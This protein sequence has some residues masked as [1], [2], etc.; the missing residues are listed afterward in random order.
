MKSFPKLV[1]AVASLLVFSAVASTMVV[2]VSAPASDFN[3][4]VPSWTGTISVEANGSISYSGSGNHVLSESSTNVYALNGNVYGSI[5]FMRNNSEFNGN[6]YS[7]LSSTTFVPFSFILSNTNNVKV[8]NLNVSSQVYQAGVTVSSSTEDTLSNLNI[9]ASV[10]SL[11]LGANTSHISVTGSNFSLNSGSKYN[12]TVVGTGIIPY[13][14]APQITNTTS[15]VKFLNDSIYVNDSNAPLGAM[16]ITSNHTLING[17]HMYGNSFFGIALNS[18]N[19][20]VSNSSV[21]GQYAYGIISNLF[22]QFESNITISG[23]LL[24]LSVGGLYYYPSSIV[25]DSQA[26]ITNNRIFMNQTSQTSSANVGPVGISIGEFSSQVINNLVEI[27]TNSAQVTGSLTGV[28]QFSQNFSL[29]GNVFEITQ[30]AT[31]Q[32]STA[33]LGLAGENVNISNNTFNMVNVRYGLYMASQNSVLAN[34]RIVDTGTT[35]FSGIFSGSSNLVISN[36]NISINTTGN[37]YAITPNGGNVTISNSTMAVSSQGIANGVISNAYF[38]GYLNVTGNTLSLGKSNQQYGIVTYSKLSYDPQ[39]IS[40]NTILL[41]NGTSIL[42]GIGINSANGST[43]SGNYISGSSGLH[44][45]PF[46]GIT[47]NEFENSTIANNV[48]LGNNSNIPGTMGLWLQNMHNTSI[49]NNSISEFNNSMKLYNTG[50]DSFVGNYF[51][52]SYYAL[53][54]T[55]T[56]YSTFYH[57]DFMNYRAATFNI[58]TSSHDVFDAALPVGGNYWQTYSG[59]DGNHDGIGD[60]PFTVNGTFADQYPLVKPW[61][62]PQAVFHAPSGI[63][64]TSWQVTFNGKTV[65]S[66]GDTI[67]FSILDGVS[68]TYN[69][70]YYNSTLYYTNTLNGSILYN[71]SGAS[72]EVPYLHYSYIEG[73]LN[74]T[75][76]T[77]YINGKQIAISNDTFNV[78][79]T[80]GSYDVE[81]VAAGYST[82][83]HTYNITPGETVNVSPTLQ[84]IPGNPFPLNVNY[85]LAI[86]AVAAVAA[87]TALYLRGRKQK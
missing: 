49:D 51:N 73:Q 11:D 25:V 27:S 30:R 69:Y 46:E 42:A 8:E 22:D 1:F 14:G 36:Q 29:I 82:F 53:N 64:G 83:N 66:T 60:T 44:P 43:V 38:N 39:N 72:I 86:V 84:K 79:V 54:M 58:S 4:T 71:G 28:Y 57:N 17:L 31:N 70:T 3:T 37:A 67:S 75:N 63:N 68:R 13:V 2:S 26:N 76:L 33:Y 21:I 50:N 20:M 10:I 23:N 18:S 24:N 40:K 12:Y 48:V 45:N 62:R 78:T 81:I 47:V 61:T 7:I 34:N 32:S 65:Q 35:G 6:G 41:D 59:T 80:A 85:I 77:V 9:S 16:N 15:Y 52:N 5:N 19:V 74:L 87:G 56:N 55:S